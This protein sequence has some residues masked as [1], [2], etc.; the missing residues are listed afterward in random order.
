M[1][2]DASRAQRTFRNRET[3]R[4][5]TNVNTWTREEWEI[6]LEKFV[7]TF[8]IV[9]TIKSR[10]LRWTYHVGRFYQKETYNK[11]YA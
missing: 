4:Y 10:I 3:K 1:V 6:G 2:H 7:H 9:R 5:C 11:A 8:N